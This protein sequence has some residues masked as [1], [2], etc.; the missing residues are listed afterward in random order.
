MNET[1]PFGATFN[2]WHVSL[3]AGAHLGRLGVAPS[4][5]RQSL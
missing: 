5:T 4:T 2:E 1:E 3:G